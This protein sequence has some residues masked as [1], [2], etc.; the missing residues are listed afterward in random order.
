MDDRT[1]IKDHL[2]GPDV[3]RAQFDE[4]FIQTGKR[5]AELRAESAKYRHRLRAAEA[6]LAAL[7]AEAGK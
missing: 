3:T 7:K 4:L 5:I 1:R 6:E 2:A